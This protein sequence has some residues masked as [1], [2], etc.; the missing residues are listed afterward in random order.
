M[1]KH[2]LRK[3]KRGAFGGACNCSPAVPAKGGKGVFDLHGWMPGIFEGERG[4]GREEGG[5]FLSSF[6]D[7]LGKRGRS[8]RRI[9]LAYAL[10]HNTEREGEGGSRKMVAIFYNTRRK[11]KSKKG[12]VHRTTR[13][14]TSWERKG[15][16][17]NG[18]GPAARFT[19]W[20]RGEKKRERTTRVVPPSLRLRKEEKKKKARAAHPVTLHRSC[21]YMGGGKGEER[22]LPQR[23]AFH[24][25]RS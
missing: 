11:K 25:C 6:E 24:A 15:K 1:P 20:N 16:K 9:I 4:R 18:A 2:R 22:H 19:R 14:S 3:G 13:L 5:I 10:L 17:R 7:A 12:L 8:F 21:S 23:G